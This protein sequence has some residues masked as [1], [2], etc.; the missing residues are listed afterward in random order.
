MDLPEVVCCLPEAYD[1]AT[2]SPL[3]SSYFAPRFS[4]AFVV[5]LKKEVHYLV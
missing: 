4:P 1:K 2:R 3:T 5:K